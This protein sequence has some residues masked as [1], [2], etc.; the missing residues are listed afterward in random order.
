MAS[1]EYWLTGNVA[2]CAA[3]DFAQ[4]RLPPNI[5]PKSFVFLDRYINVVDTTPNGDL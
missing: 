5:W 2:A 3:T 4:D 1:F